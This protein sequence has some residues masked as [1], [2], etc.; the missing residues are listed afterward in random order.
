MKEIRFIAVRCA[1]L[2][3][4][5]LLGTGFGYAQAPGGQFSVS[6]TP[7]QIQWKPI[8]FGQSVT[9]K[10]NAIT[11]GADGSVVISSLNGK[12]KVTGAHDGIP[13][14]YTAF[15]PA[16]YNF[17]LSATI[18]VLTYANDNDASKPK[19]NNQEGFGIMVRDA[20][21]VEGDS[22]VFASNIV[23]GG[24]YRGQIQAVMRENVEE[25]SGYGATMSSV[26]LN[27][28]FP[29]ADT[30]VKLT[31][32]KTNSG[33]QVFLGEDKSG[34]AVFYRPALMQVQDKAKVYV[35][36]FAARN[37]SI[38]VSDIGLSFSDPK[39]D[40]PAMPEPPKPAV[41]SLNILSPS[42][43]ASSEYGLI[44]SA[45]VDGTLKATKSGAVVFDDLK[46]SAGKERVQM[47]GLAP[48]ENSLDLSFVPDE[49]QF[50]SSAAAV[51]RQLKL[52]VKSYGLS[53]TPIRVSPAGKPE[54]DGTEAKPLD[55]ATAPCTLR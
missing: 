19:P 1:A 38:R 29:G 20:I 25:K 16:A 50:V 24:G 55:L 21:G 22:S 27:A 9:A 30:K 33:Y 53:S 17:S 52:T 3:T 34:A 37:A 47:L 8:V 28:K 40:P 15:D 14:Y 4:M 2:L 10:D 23:Y 18:E 26:S 48:G 41:P 36:F 5:A 44:V 42:E 49:G 6:F 46:L 35:G 31:V 54:G 43:T 11:V 51:T 32:E 39:Q 7:S 45:N 12:G 13:Y